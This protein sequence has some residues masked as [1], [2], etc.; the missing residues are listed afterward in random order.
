MRLP[1]YPLLPSSAVNATVPHLPSSACTECAM[2]TGCRTV[3]M[4]ADGAAGGLL[5][6]A[7]F[8]GRSD[9]AHG[10]PFISPAGAHI[11]KLLSGYAGPVAFDHA[12]RCAP[13]AREVKPKLLDTCRTYLAATILETAPTR[14]IT[15]GPW[16]AYGVLG[17]KPNLGSLTRAHGWHREVTDDG[18]LR[19]VPVFML[20]APS[21]VL[22]NRILAA[23]FNADFAWAVAADLDPPQVDRHADMVDRG[24]VTGAV[25]ECLYAEFLTYDTETSG[26]MW[27]KDFRVETITLWPHGSSAGGW[28][29]DRAELDDPVLRAALTAVLTDRR[30]RLVGHNL[31]Y[32]A[33]A[34]RADPTLAIVLPHAA[35]H[36]DTRLWRKLLA[37]DAV[38]AR[39]ETSAEELGMGGHKEEAQAQVGAVCAELNSLASEAGRA[40]LKSGKDRAPVRT[41]A[42]DDAGWTR[43]GVSARCLDNLRSGRAEAIQYAY[44]FMQPDVRRRYNARDTFVTDQLAARMIPRVAAA[45]NLQRLWDQVTA[46]AMRALV[47][48]EAEGAPVSRAAFQLVEHHLMGELAQVAKRLAAYGPV[49]FNSPLQVAALLYDK[50]RLPPYRGGRGTDKDAL[51]ALAGKHPIVADITEHRHLDKMLGTYARGMLSAIRE[52]GRIHASFLLDGA[53]TGRLSSADPN[54]QNIPRAKGSPA[55]KMIRDGFTSG[56]DDWVIVEAD[57]SQV[58]LRVAAMVS[59]DPKMIELFRAGVDFHAA[60]ARMIAPTAWGIS[61]AQWD[62]MTPDMC[63]EYRSKTKPVNFGI[64][65]GKTAAGLAAE[66]KTSIAKTEAILEAVLGQFPVLRKAMEQTLRDARR[67]GGVMVQWGGED[68]NWRWLTAIA[69]QGDENEGRRRNAEN[70]AWNTRIQGGAAHYATASLMP[71]M[72]AYEAEGLQARLMFPVHDSLVTR[73]PRSE[74]DEVARIKREVMTS[75]WCGDVPLVVDFKAGKTWGSMQSFTIPA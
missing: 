40:P 74:R 14:I 73:C 16:A 3:G 10:R 68:A 21:V 71:V 65:Y 1:L 47:R 33:L 23:R 32:D 17:R 35:L 29:W 26:L 69:D 57:Y 36:G 7:D 61:H 4:R 66:L 2:A 25:T 62:A 22:R 49:N 43:A 51:A 15:L 50:L 38:D 24:N 67:D 53:D 39:L 11:R 19:W 63:E 28:T 55:G 45:P 9:D 52:D 59:G 72:D 20:P 31:K 13:G 54:L 64:H 60:T 18:D 42:L 5:V 12:L 70:G 27:D 75:H 30:T 6:V 48:M 8:P 44:K 46:P 56:D 34:L 37:G 41:P 58:E